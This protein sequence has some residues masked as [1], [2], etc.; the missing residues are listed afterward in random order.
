M[1]KN[2]FLFTLEFS[3]LLFLSASP[4]FAA[5]F[6]VLDSFINFKN[7]PA[8]EHTP[9]TQNISYKPDLINATKDNAQVILGD[10]RI[11][12]SE[13]SYLIDGKNVGAVVNQTSVNSL[14][15]NLKVTLNNYKKANLVALYA[16]EHGIDGTIKAGAYISSTKDTATGKT[17]YS[18][19]QATREPSYDMMKNIDVMLFDLQDIGS[20]TYTYTST[21]NKCMIAC[22]KYGVKMVVLD[23]PNPVS[24]KYTQGFMNTDE[25]LSFVGIDNTPMAHGLTAG[26]L[27]QFF[28]RKIGCDLAVVPMK[29]YTRDMIWQDTGLT[30]MQTSPNI[31]TIEAA[32]GYMATGMSDGTGLGMADYF[33][34]SGMSGLNSNAF[35]EQMNLYNLPGVRFIPENKGTRGGVRLNVTDYHTFNPARTGYYLMAT[36]NKLKTLR[37]QVYT[38]KGQPTMFYKISGDKALANALLQFKSPM[39]IE[40]MYRQACENFK[41]ETQK[42]HLY[43]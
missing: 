14:G 19:Y 25:A 27:A 36:A 31:P 5:D 17:V 8:V 9:V 12:T 33:S 20:R 42:Y 6:S 21:M 22:K 2:L 1:K 40:S 41:A 11:F 38:A 10:E 16:P 28:N 7:P 15:E 3:F 35:A 4:T 39:E 32:F 34:W 29:N 26:E 30:F 18:L 43:N 24:C 23:R 37:F 13:F